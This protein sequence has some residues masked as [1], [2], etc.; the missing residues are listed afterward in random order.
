MSGK[1]LSPKERR[2]VAEFLKDQNAKQAAIRAGYSPKTSETQGPRLY[3]KVQVRA[4]IDTELA[5]IQEKAGVTQ[6]R[7]L[8]A[9][10]NIAEIDPRKLFH[11]D[12][13]LK[14]IHELPDDVA[15]TIASIESDEL[16]GHLKKIKFWDKPKALEL[17]G[18]HLKMFVDRNEITDGSGAPVT[19]QFMPAN[20]G[21]SKNRPSTDDKGL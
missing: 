6:E 10:L 21:K 5:K 2:F 7:I 12:G 13:T 14:K 20:Y 3:R 18:R 9:L 16:K 19:I 15:L 4:A 11:R 8:N 17:L 1:P